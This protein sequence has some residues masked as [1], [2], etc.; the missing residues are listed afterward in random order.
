MNMSIAAATVADTG[1]NNFTM[2]DGANPW[3]RAGVTD[4]TAI[5]NSGRQGAREQWMG[6]ALNVN[7]NAVQLPTYVFISKPAAAL[8]TANTLSL[9]ASLHHAATAVKTVR[10]R[11]IKVS[12]QMS[13][14]AESSII[15]VHRITAAPTGTAV[16]GAAATASL[17]PFDTR[18]PAAEATATTSLT[19]A[20]STGLLTHLVIT[21]EDAA[22]L[23]GGG[24]VIYDWQEAGQTKAI[25]IR[26]GVLEGIAVGIISSAGVTPTLTV[27][28]QFT[29]E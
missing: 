13:A 16:T 14:V 11:R 6:N 25:T 18:D 24:A 23:H 10:I 17:T 21:S 26:S 7:V 9:R 22:A 20:T 15:E 2:S 12:G 28:I 8:L 29:E 4:V 5:T 19:A 27:E 1:S 3:R